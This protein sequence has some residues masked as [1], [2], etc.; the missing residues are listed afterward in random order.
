IN[1]STKNSYKS[2]IKLLEEIKETTNIVYI[3]FQKLD[4]IIDE[5]NSSDDRITI[6]NLLISAD[7]LIA[8]NFP[9][10]KDNVLNIDTKIDGRNFQITD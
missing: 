7:K 6:L 9:N 2:I 1:L 4:N 8:S 5:I 3:I 10:F